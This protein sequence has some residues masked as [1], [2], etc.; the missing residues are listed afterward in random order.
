MCRGD[1][2]FC[3]V[4]NITL[5]TL[6]IHFSG[7]VWSQINKPPAIE[8]GIYIRLHNSH[9]GVS[10]LCYCRSSHNSPFPGGS[11]HK[12]LRFSPSR[13]RTG[14]DWTTSSDTGWTWT[15]NRNDDRHTLNHLSLLSLLFWRKNND[16]DND[17]LCEAGQPTLPPASRESC[18]T[19]WN[20]LTVNWSDGHRQHRPRQWEDVSEWLH[21]KQKAEWAW[22]RHEMIEEQS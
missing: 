7:Q 2:L 3:K 15:A 12:P 17:K 8:V 19:L 20:S 16:G 1:V 11:Y 18:T 10:Y 9:T 14:P 5:P 6:N 4:T 13:I 21:L 22:K